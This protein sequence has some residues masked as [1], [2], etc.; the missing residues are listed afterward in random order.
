MYI[1]IIVSLILQVS[2]YEK[3]SQGHCVS[4]AEHY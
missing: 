3:L 1:Y 4:A 2:W